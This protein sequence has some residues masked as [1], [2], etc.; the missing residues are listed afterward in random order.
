MRIYLL[1]VKFEYIYIYILT[2]IN[3]KIIFQ[4]L[5]GHASWRHNRTRKYASLN[6]HT[7][8]PKNQMQGIKIEGDKE[9]EKY[10]LHSF[11]IWKKR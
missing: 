11:L 5:V 3:G 10:L 4:I 2:D 8:M 6:K 7:N 9:R 1:L